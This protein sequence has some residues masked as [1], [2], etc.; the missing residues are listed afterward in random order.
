[1]PNNALQVDNDNENYNDNDNDNDNDKENSNGN[2][3]DNDNKDN[4][5]KENSPASVS[6][7]TMP[8][9]LTAVPGS[10]GP[11]H[12]GSVNVAA[13]VEVPASTFDNYRKMLS[14]VI[15][16]CLV[17]QQLYQTNARLW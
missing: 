1:M 9:R 13:S 14:F 12:S 15:I 10:Q 11:N 8:S 5:D 6:C 4:N 7:Q 2:D 3:N 17:S 16:V